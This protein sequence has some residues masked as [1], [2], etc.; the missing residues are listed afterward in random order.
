LGIS[1]AGASFRAFHVRVMLRSRW[2]VL[3]LLLSSLVPAGALAAIADPNFTETTLVSG[4]E[5][6]I[7]AMAWA[8][9]GSPRLFLLVKTGQVLVVENG[10]LLATPFAVVDPIVTSGECGLLGLAFDPSFVDNGYVYLFV[11]VSSTE[12]QIVRYTA[13]GDLGVDKTVIVAGLPTL[14][15]NHNGGALGFGADGKLYWAIGDNGG[16]RSGVDTDLLSL[17][18]KVGRANADG[19]VPGDNPFFDGDGPNNDY[20]WARGFRNPFTL[21]FQPAT[22]R[23]WLNVVGNRMEQVFTPQAGDH[24]GWDDYEASQPAGFIAPVISYWTNKAPPV[25]L[26]TPGAARSAGVVTITTHRP[27]PLRPGAKVTI[28]GVTDPSF[29]GPTII[30]SVGSL[31]TFSFEQPGPDANSGGGT[32]TPELIGGCVTGGEFWDSTAVPADYRGNFFFGDYNTGVVMRAQL[33][34]GT[35]ITRIDQWATGVDGIVDM[36]LGPDGDMY[37]AGSTGSVLQARFGF[38]SQALVVSRQHVRIA[39]GGSAALSV[40]LAMAPAG[41]QRVNATWLSGDSDVAVTEGGALTFTATSWATPQRVLLSAA[42]DADSLEDIARVRISATGIAAQ[43]IDV[44]VIDDETSSLIVTPDALSIDEGTSEQLDVSLTQPPPGAL[45]VSVALTAGDTTASVAGGGLLSFDSSNWSLPQTVTVSAAQDDDAEGGTAILTVSG[46]G[47]S[48]RE[49]Q[50]TI[51]DDD[52]GFVDPGAGGA[53]GQG[54]AAAGDG[55]GG[56]G[57]AGAGGVAPGG[58]RGA[59]L[60]GATGD[61]GVS[62]SSPGGAADNTGTAGKSSSSGG[63]CD[64]RAAKPAR[65]GSSQ[66]LAWFLALMLA[67]VRRARRQTAA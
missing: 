31:K 48:P 7:T 12:Q 9:D 27:H 24:G 60:G 43:V 17:A 14:G 37:Y 46:D 35:Q 45:E 5:G 44:G 42:Q 6:G 8:P 61:G 30:T 23:L 33:S 3:A 56:A 32:A 1:L 54:G 51:R 57:L 55:D 59:G 64:C 62:D 34:T 58:A 4:I 52:D 67:G 50:V 11:T 41:N 29:N 36:A 65:S 16:L 2:L 21:S 10:Q 66:S 22:G 47:L 15:R 13:S 39:E 25:I 20:I 53:G 26:E 19:S 28:A 49:V 18:S 40:R 38:T 63:G